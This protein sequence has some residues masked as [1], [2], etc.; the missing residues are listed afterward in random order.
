MGNENPTH[1]ARLQ[2]R[3]LPH[4]RQAVSIDALE[5]THSFFR[6]MRIWARQVSQACLLASQLPHIMQLVSLAT[7]TDGVPRSTVNIEKLSNQLLQVKN[8][9][10]S[11]ILKLARFF[12]VHQLLKLRSP[13]ILN[14]ISRIWTEYSQSTNLIQWNC[15]WSEGDSF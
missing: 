12:E 9:Q 5:V 4:R 3:I 7:V 11:C 14:L 15:N 6:S 10:W 1:F 2:L 13:I 8:I